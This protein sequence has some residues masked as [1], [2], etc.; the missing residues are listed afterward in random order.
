MITREHRAPSCSAR[1]PSTAWPPL[2]LPLPLPLTLT[3]TPALTLTPTLNLRLTRYGV[4]VSPNQRH[5][6]Y[7]WAAMRRL[8]T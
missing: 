2:S 6:R 1:A 8:G 7:F 3:L 4:G 5:V